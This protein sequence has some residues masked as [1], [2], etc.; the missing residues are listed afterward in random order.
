MGLVAK[1]AHAR[2]DRAAGDDDDFLAGLP[3]RGEL[4]DDLIE[5][6]G[7][8]LLAAIGEDAGA[9]LDHDAGDIS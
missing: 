3:E 2:A 8:E 9:E 4:R 7:V 6:G 1:R 5:L